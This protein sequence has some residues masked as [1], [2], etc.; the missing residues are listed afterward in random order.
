MPN[1]YF[2]PVGKDCCPEVLSG[3]ARKLFQALLEREKI[4]LESTVPLKVHFGEKGNRTYLKPATYQGIIDFLA[5]KGVRSCYMET[6]VLYGGERFERERHIRL[7]QAH[8]FTNL[9]IV[10]A[11]GAAGEEAI[12]IPLPHH[13]FHFKTCS[14]GKAFAD[15]PQI[16]VMSHFKG[17]MLAGFG[18]AL[19]QLSMG[20]ASKGGKMAMH[21]S[22]KPRIRN[23]KCK[24]CKVC[25]NRCNA[26]AITIGK[27]SCIDPGKC[28]GCGACF[29]I[30][31]HKAISIVS[32]GGLWNALFK[33]R[34]FREKLAEYALASHS[35]HRNIYLNFAVAVTA[36]CDCEPRPMRP[37]VENIG[38]FASTDPVAIDKAC[39]DAV[40]AKGKVF[41]GSEQLAYAEKIGV[42]SQNYTLNKIEN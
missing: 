2:I 18:G 42:G 22:V 34:F 24:R 19:K 39:Y 26:G 23:W 21:L 28:I 16:I 11:D 3:G 29:S 15:Y 38:I 40:A 36:G 9:P 4:T 27:R 1:V 5:E 30:C 17:H 13:H 32:L 12:E 14:I 8:G 6:S 25:L 37:C 33:G 41:K 31:P 7:A 10:I 20:F 35:T